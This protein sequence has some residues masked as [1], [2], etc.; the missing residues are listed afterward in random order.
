[1]FGA[2]LRQKFGATPD[3][4]DPPLLHLHQTAQGEWQML[5]APWAQ[6]LLIAVNQNCIDFQE[7]GWWVLERREVF[8]GPSAVI[9][10]V[11]L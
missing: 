8:S 3:G 5:V 6:D 11:P 10:H 7:F 1:M 2:K 9:P 4:G